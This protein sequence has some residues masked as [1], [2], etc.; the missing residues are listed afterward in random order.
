MHLIPCEYRSLLCDAV[1]PKLLVPIINSFRLK[2]LKGEKVMFTKL[3]VDK[4]RTE[5]DDPETEFERLIIRHSEI[6]QSAKKVVKG[7]GISNSNSF[8]VNYGNYRSILI[9][10]K[11]IV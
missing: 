7:S 1:L 4:F 5:K 8:H 11:Q 2:L 9:F 10:V 6:F 3:I